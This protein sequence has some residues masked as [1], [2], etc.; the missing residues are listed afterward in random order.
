MFRIV[1]PL[2][3][4]VLLIASAPSQLIRTAGV[5]AGAVAAD[6][7]WNY[8]FAGDLLVPG[9]RWGIDVGGYVEWLTHPILSI[10]SEAHF[11][12]KGFQSSVQIVSVESPA[13]TG[14]YITQKAR[15]EYLSLPILAKF[16][17][18]LDGVTPYLVAGPRIDFKLN[19]SSDGFGIVLDDFRSSEIGMTFGLGAE[20]RLHPAI[21]LGVEAR[22]SPNLQPGYESDLLKVYNRSFEFLLVAGF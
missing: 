20:T 7:D 3:M 9:A 1:I 13:G 21:T 5:K 8:R 15:V 2:C 19:S 11:I 4:L 18:D 12:Q 6:Q 17:V 16:R 10:S 14:M 22:F